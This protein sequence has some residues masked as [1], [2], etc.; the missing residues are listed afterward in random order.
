MSPSALV[1]LGALSACTGSESAPEGAAAPIESSWMADLVAAPASFAER[2]GGAREGWIALHRND[3]RAAA[4][5]GGDPEARSAR[6][7]A[8]FYAVLAAMDAEVW[9]RMGRAW[10]ARGTLPPAS[11]LPW[12]IG[13]A[14]ADAGRDEEAAAWPAGEAAVP[15]VAERKRLH[16]RVRAGAAD[17]GSLEATQADALLVEPVEGGARELADP[18]VLR[19]H[20]R[21]S[22]QRADAH[23]AVDQALFSSDLGAPLHLPAAPTDPGAD[24]D[25]CRGTVRELD[26]SLDAWRTS[27]SANAS[28][29]GRQLLDDLRL[30]EGARARALVELAVTALESDRPTCALALSH[31]AIDHESPRAIGPV[32]SPTLFAA[33]ASAELRVGHTREALDAI[34]V[35]VAPWPETRGLDET[36]STLVVLEGLDRRGDSRE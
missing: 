34:E 11:L 26:A 20:A 8:K 1:L 18:W 9:S 19:T 29:E 17:L 2:V 3:W 16:D 32:N 15:S 10:S 24:A 36:L 30:V 7:F 14:L 6:E 13:A 31:L 22:R 5:A 12:L 33:L 25:A 28:P 27:A 35:L 21:V 4:A 23:A